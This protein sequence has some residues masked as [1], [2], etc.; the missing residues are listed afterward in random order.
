VSVWFEGTSQLRCT[1]EDVKQSLSNPGEHY[2]EVTRLMPGLTSVE[3]INQSDD[4][5]AIRTNEGLMRR[6]N[7]T[8]RIEAGQ[9]AV[10]FDEVYEAGSRITV[11]SRFHDEFTTSESGV[12]YY[13]VISSVQAPG[14]GG[15]F[16]RR[17]GS[18]KIGG[19]LLTATKAHIENSF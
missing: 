19:A 17:F 1:L 18:S 7:L 13:L 6:S 15:F 8:K 5:L 4:S 2:L 16:Y 3:L 9:V 11:S 10:D 12:T 14:F